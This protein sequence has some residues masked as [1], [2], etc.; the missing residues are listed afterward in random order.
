MLRAVGVVLIVVGIAVTVLGVAMGVQL[1]SPL[2]QKAV[3]I[4]VFVG[5]GFGIAW[6]GRRL[7]WQR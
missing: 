5:V 6:S 2:W 7:G 4:L 3:A 1:H